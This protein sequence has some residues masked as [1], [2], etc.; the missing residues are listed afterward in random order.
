MIANPRKPESCIYTV[1]WVLQ[2][3][4]DYR[5]SCHDAQKHYEVDFHKS[6]NQSYRSISSKVE[7]DAS[8]SEDNAFNSKVDEDE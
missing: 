5:I 6:N 1:M 3:Q 7:H 4:E 2:P 8:E